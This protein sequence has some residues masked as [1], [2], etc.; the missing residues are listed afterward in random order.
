MSYDLMVFEPGSAPKTHTAF[1]AWYHEQTKWKE[2]HSYADPAI[3]SRRLQAL[4][5]EVRPYFPSEDG[6]FD[7]R[8]LPS[9]D[10]SIS[11]H[12]FGHH[13]MYAE[14]AWSRAIIATEKLKHLACAHGL[15]LFE[16][17]S[18]GTEVWLPGEHGEL[19]LMPDESPPS[20]RARLLRWLG[21]AD[22]T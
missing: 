5:S 13:F 10:R 9:G 16:T 15:G 7:D 4:F 14:F 8:N 1:I 12:T 17:S 3:S 21:I 18:E 20:L 2:G 22:P 6:P 19:K 11:A